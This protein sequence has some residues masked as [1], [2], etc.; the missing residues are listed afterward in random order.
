MICGTGPKAVKLGDMVE[1]NGERGDYL[2]ADE[3]FAKG[4][5]GDEGESL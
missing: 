3:Y 1:F 5:Q 4:G 2:R